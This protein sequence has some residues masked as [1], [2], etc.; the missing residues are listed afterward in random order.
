MGTMLQRIHPQY[1]RTVALTE[2]RYCGHP[3]SGFARRMSIIARL[4]QLED[5]RLPLVIVKNGRDPVQYASSS[6]LS[7]RRKPRNGQLDSPGL[8][9]LMTVCD[10][11]VLVNFI[12]TATIIGSARQLMFPYAPSQL[13]DSEIPFFRLNPASDCCEVS[14]P[15]LRFNCT[16]T[17]ECQRRAL[18]AAANAQCPPV[19][20]RV[21]EKVKAIHARWVRTFGYPDEWAGIRNFLQVFNNL[22]PEDNPQRW[23]SMDLRQLDIASLSN[24]TFAALNGFYKD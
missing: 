12:A 15:I 13:P 17:A 8:S 3:E 21:L 11:L 16:D 2:H 1:T 6:F 14:I 9:E 24:A 5:L 7:I 23:D 20:Q 18:L 19:S 10:R 4:M 22:S